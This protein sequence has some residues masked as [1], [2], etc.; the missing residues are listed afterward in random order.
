M[1]HLLSPI[2]VLVGN[3]DVAWHGGFFSVSHSSVVPGGGVNAFLPFSITGGFRQLAAPLPPRYLRAH[4]LLAAW[5]V[6][7]LTISTNP[8]VCEEALTVPIVGVLTI[9]T[10]PEV[11]EEALTAPS[12]DGLTMSINPAVSVTSLALWS[13]SANHPKRPPLVKTRAPAPAVFERMCLN[14]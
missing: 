8:K 7:V 4:E 10:N 2:F 14:S 12:A 11:C 5:R 3:M 13:I 6:D 9:S 1:S